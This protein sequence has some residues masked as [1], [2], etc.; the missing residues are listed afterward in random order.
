MSTVVGTLSVNVASGEATLTFDTAKQQLNSF[1]ATAKNVSTSFDSS[2]TKTVESTAHLQNS[3]GLLDN[4]IRGRLP[5]AFADLIRKFSDTEIVMNLLPIAGVVAGFAL[6]GLVVAKVAEAHE[7]A[8]EATRKSATAAADAAVKNADEAKSIELENLKLD[9]Q[10]AKLE[11]KPA[12]NYLREA[13]LEASTAIDELAA[14]Y[15]GDFA[16]MDTLVEQQEGLWARFVRFTKDAISGVGQGQGYD[17]VTQRW[18]DLTDAIDSANTARQKLAEDTPGTDQWLADEKALSDALEVQQNK[19]SALVYIYRDDKNVLAQ[20]GEQ[21]GNTA[22]EVDNL[23]REM[24]QLHKK[25]AVGSGTQLA[26]DIKANL[27]PL[28]GPEMQALLKARNNAAIDDLSKKWDG[29]FESAAKKAPEIPKKLN[30]ALADVH[31]PDFQK[32]FTLDFTPESEAQTRFES[33]SLEADKQYRSQLQHA[34]DEYVEKNV[35]N[36]RDMTAQIQ[37]EQGN[38]KAAFDI[39]NAGLSGIGLNVAKVAEDRELLAQ[40][41]QEMSELQSEKQQLESDK[42]LLDPSDTANIDKYTAAIHQ[43][44][45]KMTELRIQQAQAEAETVK[46][47]TSWQAYFQRM[48]GETADLSTTIRTNLQQSVTQFEAGFANAMSKS[49]VEGKN[50]G[51]AMRQV[52]AQFLESMLSALIQW[53]EHWIISHT[54]AA[55]LANSTLS[56]QVGPTLAANRVMQT[57]AAGLAAAEAM[58]TAPFPIDLS[59]GPEVFAEAMSFSLGGIVPGYGNGDTVPAML[60]PGEGVLPKPMMDKLSSATSSDG[61]SGLHVHYSPTNHIKAWD[62]SDVKDVLDQHKDEFIKQAK[63][64]IRR[65]HR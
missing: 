13:I 55:A 22:S 64:E 43:L 60:T 16:K 27:K 28:F 1:D 29:F 10:I 15:A 12:Q 58:A 53:L 62:G 42:S 41:T 61:G 4:T 14:K 40:I 17:T 25:A 37:T 11:H 44:M 26:D 24:D 51:Q 6:L 59:I 18:H 31:P 35:Q 56:A 54:I 7:K 21:A 19:I 38:L 65:R 20:L 9:D 30:E 52:A 32:L 2:M 50:F 33:A 63:K 46:L 49:I 47:G 5:M 36:Y 45:Q 8:A 57:S 34:M 23:S 39:K 3:I 48:Q